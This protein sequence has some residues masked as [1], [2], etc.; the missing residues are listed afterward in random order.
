M[1]VS[2]AGLDVFFIT[3]A[4]SIFLIALLYIVRLHLTRHHLEYQQAHTGDEEEPVQA[5]GRR[6]F[7]H[8][9][10]PETE[11]SAMRSSSLAA[12]GRQRGRE[13]K[14]AEAEDLFPEDEKD[15]EVE[16]DRDEL[17]QLR[18]LSQMAKKRPAGSRG[19]DDDDDD[20]ETKDEQRIDVERRPAIV[21]LPTHPLSSP[22]RDRRLKSPRHQQQLEVVVAV[23]QKQEEEKAEQPSALSSSSSS[24]V[25]SSKGDG[26]HV[27]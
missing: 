17:E 12:G 3:V 19:D 22:A 10:G 21:S 2:L 13:G 26:R 6:R 18:M 14:E 9:R 24:P 7:P 8:R 23:E 15:A 20:E 1:G 11:M 27:V 5:D 25:S 16:F 4:V